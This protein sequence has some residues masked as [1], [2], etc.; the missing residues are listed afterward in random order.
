MLIV[1]LDDMA[2]HRDSELINEVELAEKHGHEIEEIDLVS[3]H[4]GDL[5]R[6]PASPG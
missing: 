2:N 3:N 5:G 1:L 6:E 4:G